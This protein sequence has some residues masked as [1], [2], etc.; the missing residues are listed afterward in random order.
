MKKNFSWLILITI[1]NSFTG[2]SQ[3]TIDVY[4]WYYPGLQDYEKQEIDIEIDLIIDGNIVGSESINAHPTKLYTSVQNNDNK[5]IYLD[6]R[7]SSPEGWGLRSNPV[8]Y[9]RKIKLKRYDDLYFDLKRDSENYVDTK[10]YS[11]AK[12]IYNRMLDEEI[13]T[14]ENQRLEILRGLAKIHK[15]TGDLLEFFNANKFI[16]EHIEWN[17]INDS[18]GRKTVFLKEYWDS[19]LAAR[20]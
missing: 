6:V 18:N 13:Y 19:I 2:I 12:R 17:S 20:V 9:S 5:P 11:Y 1:V 14:T 7:I 10:N 4:F 8:R 15:L 3:Q 16:A